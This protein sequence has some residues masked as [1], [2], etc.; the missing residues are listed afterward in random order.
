MG[1]VLLPAIAAAPRGG[2]SQESAGQVF[3]FLQAIY[4]QH[5]K[6]LHEFLED[7]LGLF[8]TTFPESELIVNAHTLLAQLYKEKGETSLALGQCLKTVYLYPDTNATAVCRGL[9]AS[10]IA[11]EKKFKDK[12]EQ[13]HSFLMKK[14]NAEDT[15]TRFYHYLSYLILLDEP[16]LRE[17][18]LN[19]LR[20]FNGWF[21]DDARVDSTTLWIA[22]VY[23]KMKKMPEAVAA[24]SKL[25]YTHPQSSLLPYAFYQEGRLL[26]EELGAHEKALTVLANV[27]SLYITS[28][29]AG[30]S[31]FLMGTIK[32]KKIKDYAA[33]I[34]DY[35]KLVTLYPQHKRAVDALLAVASIHSEKIKDYQAAIDAYNRIVV[36]YQAHPDGVKALEEIGNIYKDK[37]KDY[38]Q[39][40]EY[41]ARIAE[42]YPVYE[43]AAD[44]LL[45][46]GALCEE[47]VKD[48]T[49]ALEYYQMVVDKFP[50]HKKAAEAEKRVARVKLKIGN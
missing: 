32:E 18:T 36:E 39:S 11:E 14:I 47:R 43:Q 30:A 28:D 49:K 2:G 29:Y 21:P 34:A 35:E 19:E 6:K 25:H 13:L 22:D 10:L 4:D 9:A 45:E 48:Y 8:M 17:W 40:A 5:D 20:R 26:Y 7:E 41:Y 15:A 1:V 23:V 50:E 27:V 44:M 38:L 37:I 12:Q 16:D 42:L 3:A 31:L 24:Y 46:A 33:A